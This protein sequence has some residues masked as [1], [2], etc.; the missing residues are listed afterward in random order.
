MKVLIVR[1]MMAILALM[2]LHLT[3]INGNH[4]NETTRRLEAEVGTKEYCERPWPVIDLFLPV[5][6]RP[7]LNDMHVNTRNEWA[8]LFLS[9]Y[10]HF[11]PIKTAKSRV[12]F[13]IDA[14]AAADKTTPEY[15]D[16]DNTLHKF[17]D[18]YPHAEY[19]VVTNNYDQS[20]WV[21][22]RWRQ[23]LVGFFADLYVKAEY[24][25]FVD[26]D[27]TF[28]TYVDREDIFENGKPIV[29]GR[30]G[31]GFGI[32]FTLAA[33]WLMGGLHVRF[34]AILIINM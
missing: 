32:F 12:T 5:G 19:Q 24:V 28:I 26:G 9:S 4:V 18:G 22:G 7:Y 17:F 23:Q 29:K 8:D 20:V 10:L 34:E 3:L 1:K 31:G 6:I 21:H 11:F 33:E 13:V 27:S 2:S 16:F 30:F 25:G 14:E 15:K